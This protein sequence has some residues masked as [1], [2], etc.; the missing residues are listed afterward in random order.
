MIN[1][2]KLDKWINT[3][4][5]ANL[6]DFSLINDGEFGLTPYYGDALIDL[7]INDIIK[8]DYFIKLDKDN[9]RILDLTINDMSLYYEDSISYNE[10]FGLVPK[11][12][13]KEIEEDEQMTVKDL[14]EKLK[15]CDP[16]AKLF[17]TLG[18][19]NNYGPVDYIE[20]DSI[21][22]DEEDEGGVLIGEL[23]W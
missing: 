18:G 15:K 14:I 6:S 1:K 21:E 16:D 7:D 9:V 3:A 2:K 22:L 20:N 4:K 19:S 23:T 5:E 8:I 12:V 11:K 13:I 17:Y 10:Y